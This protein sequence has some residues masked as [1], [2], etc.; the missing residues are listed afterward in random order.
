MT[1][2]AKT[3]VMVFWVPGCCRYMEAVMSLVCGCNSLTPGPEVSG[4]GG[5]LMSGAKPRVG[6]AWGFQRGLQLGD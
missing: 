4:E 6:P 3:L 2:S 1:N 5:R